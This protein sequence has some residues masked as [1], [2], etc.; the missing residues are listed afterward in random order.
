MA[1][2]VSD[3]PDSQSC[4]LFRAKVMFAPLELFDTILK[5]ASNPIPKP[6]KGFELVYKSYT[7][8]SDWDAIH[9]RTQE[10]DFPTRQQHGQ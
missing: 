2:G 8:T 1:P 6:S 3:F 5:R 9:S 4:Y 10:T 7:G